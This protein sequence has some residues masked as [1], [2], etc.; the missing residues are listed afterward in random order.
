MYYTKL[1]IEN[2][3]ITINTHV[4]YNNN[5]LGAMTCRLVALSSN[6]QSSTTSIFKF[7]HIIFAINKL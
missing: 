6:D 1:A 3:D 4:T 7:Q 2:M 5:H